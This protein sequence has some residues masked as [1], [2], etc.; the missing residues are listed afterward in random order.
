MGIGK[1]EACARGAAGLR[2]TLEKD[3]LDPWQLTTRT[4]RIISRCSREV[5]PRNISYNSAGLRRKLRQTSTHRLRHE[6]RNEVGA[7]WSKG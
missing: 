6:P 4:V 1:A 3:D 2:D 7:T 5:T